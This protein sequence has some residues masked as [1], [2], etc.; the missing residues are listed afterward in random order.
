MNKSHFA[1]DLSNLMKKYKDMHLESRQKL[2]LVPAKYKA[3]PT[4]KSKFA[5]QKSEGLL[6][7]GYELSEDSF[8]RGSEL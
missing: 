4:L 3:M 6:L 5:S 1:S 7:M 8:S 2:P